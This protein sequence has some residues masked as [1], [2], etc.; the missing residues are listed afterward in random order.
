MKPGD[1]VKMNGNHFVD[2]E[3]RG[4]VWVVKSKPLVW[5]NTEVVL[6]E[7]RLGGYAVNGLTVIE[8]GVVESDLI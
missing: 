2:P 5:N 3:D 6:L 4:R 7:G 8:E 1:K